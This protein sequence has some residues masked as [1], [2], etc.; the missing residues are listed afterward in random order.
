MKVLCPRCNQTIDLGYLEKKGDQ[1]TSCQNCGLVVAATFKK[2]G[3][4]RYWEVSF[5]TPMPANKKESRDDRGGC[6]TAIWLLIL[7][8]IL[9][10]MARCDW[11]VPYKLPDETSEGRLR[12]KWKQSS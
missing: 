10:A 5:E 9:I 11:K 3:V 1:M 12:N 6:S 2:D 7:L 4:R 8:A